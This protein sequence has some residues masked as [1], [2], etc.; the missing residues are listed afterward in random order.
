MMHNGQEIGNEKMLEFFERDPIAWGE[1]HWV[2]ELFTDLFGLLEVNTAIWHGDAGGQMVEIATSAP[3]AV[4][5]FER[6]M[7]EDGVF[8]VFNFSAEARTVSF[9]DYETGEGFADFYSRAPASLSA[10]GTISLEPWSHVLL[11]RG[12]MPEASGR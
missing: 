11:V 12:A 10:G 2:G 1:P 6:E 5:A 3:D 4:Y 9:G 8:A 7:D